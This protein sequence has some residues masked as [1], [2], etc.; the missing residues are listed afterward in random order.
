MKQLFCA[1]LILAPSICAQSTKPAPPPQPV[2]TAGIDSDEC[3]DLTEY[4]SGLQQVTLAGRLVQ[5]IIADGASYQA[6]KQRA[7]TIANNRID[8]APRNSAESMRAITAPDVLFSWTAFYEL[9]PSTHIISNVYFDESQCRDEKMKNNKYD[10]QSCTQFL[11]YSLGFVEGAF[12]GSIN[13]RS[14][15]TA[16]RP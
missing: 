4:L 11:F 16:G 1:L 15:L 8:R 3:K 9:D 10:A 5:F 6:A 12:A 7:L 14:V 13:T 2:C